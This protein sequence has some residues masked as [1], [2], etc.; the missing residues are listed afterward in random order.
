MPPQ[1]RVGLN[2]ARQT[3]QAWPKPGHPYER[4]PITGTQPRSV[5]GPP[6]ANIELMPEKKVLDFK[7]APR[8]EQ[9]GTENAN[10]AEDSE[11]HI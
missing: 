1:D 3:Q 4:R 8:L 10:Q 11:H 9:V 2:N 5:R 6:H 7:L